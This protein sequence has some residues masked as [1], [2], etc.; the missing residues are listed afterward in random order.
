MRLSCDDPNTTLTNGDHGVRT[1]HVEILAA[2]ETP[3]YELNAC[4]HDRQQVPEWS[5][6]GEMATMSTHTVP[7][8]GGMGDCCMDR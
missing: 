8:G 6:K 2:G 5:G 4:R 7:Q 3:N 1:F